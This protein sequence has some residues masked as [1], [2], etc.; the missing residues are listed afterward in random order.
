MN[1]GVWLSRRLRGVLYDSPRRRLNNFGTHTSHAGTT[2]ST[3]K[4]EN[5]R[6]AHV[7]AKWLT[8][9]NLGMSEQSKQEVD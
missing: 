9:Y 5:T 4:A 7:T 3:A 6:L 2:M 1:D 8:D